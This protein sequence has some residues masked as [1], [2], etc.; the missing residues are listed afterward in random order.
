MQIEIN[1]VLIDERATVRITGSC[2]NPFCPVGEV[3]RDVDPLQIAAAESTLKRV[4]PQSAA[5]ALSGFGH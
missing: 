4:R 3:A 1:S 5:L 2:P